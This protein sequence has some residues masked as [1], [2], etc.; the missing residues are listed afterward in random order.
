[1]SIEKNYF[2]RLHE[3]LCRVYGT[4]Q[5]MMRD[6]PAIEGAENRLLSREDAMRMFQRDEVQIAARRNAVNQ[7]KIEAFKLWIEV[8]DQLAK[9]LMLN[10]EV[11]EEDGY[12]GIIRLSGD[13]IVVDERWETGEKGLLFLLMEASDILCVSNEQH[14]GKPMVQIQMGFRVCF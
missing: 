2:D 12:I 4:G 7:D 14:N 8:A 5:N 13:F 9:K 3:K 10:L 11:D 1:M 6:I